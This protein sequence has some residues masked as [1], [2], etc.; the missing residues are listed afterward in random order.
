MENEYYIKIED[1]TDNLMQVCLK[2]NYIKIF[3]TN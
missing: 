1:R 3:F 2:N